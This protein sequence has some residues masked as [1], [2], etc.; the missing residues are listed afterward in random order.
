MIFNKQV[1]HFDKANLKKLFKPAGTSN[2]EDNGQVTIIGG[3]S[4]FHG[5]P[6]LPLIV[7]SRIV[8]MVFFATPEKSVGMVAQNLK[9]KL[10]SFI[11]IPW[12]DKEEYIKK[13]DAILIGPGFMRFGSEKTPNGK[14]HIECDEECQKTKEI[15]K[16][17]LTKFPNK[18]WVIDAGSLQ[19]MDPDWIPSNAILT[20]NKKEYQILF[21]KMDPEVAAKKYNCIIVI[22]GP[23][24]LVYSKEEI[25]EVH[26]G[27]PGLTKGG[28]GD[29]QAGLTA[30]LLAKNDPL[31]S[32]CAGAFIVKAAADELQKE[33]GVYYNADDLAN[34]IPQ[35]LSSLI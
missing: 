3:S 6:I 14:R 18:K 19:T 24:T 32:A 23:T 7:A 15:T 9:S 33:K 12:E 11:W 27:N 8:D 21:G 31:L 20:P 30:A 2:G 5:A 34:K 17:L 29:V 13:S 10:M 16:A 25:I 1:H 28:T 35:T 22:K 26:G 4:L